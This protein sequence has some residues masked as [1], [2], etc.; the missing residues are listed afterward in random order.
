MSSG[1]FAAMPVRF[2]GTSRRFA[3]V[4]QTVALR[5]VTAG[6]NNRLQVLSE[7]PSTST[8]RTIE[9]RTA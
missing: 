3:A 1:P 6:T 7:P 4:Q 2:F 9:R 5:G 8:M